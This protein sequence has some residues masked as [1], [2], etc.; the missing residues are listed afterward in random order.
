MWLWG[1]IL[2]KTDA[3]RWDAWMCGGG[4]QLYGQVSSL[5]HLHIGCRKSQCWLMAHETSAGFGYLLLL[6]YQ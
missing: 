5:D 3:S 2:D 1:S 6:Y 4:R